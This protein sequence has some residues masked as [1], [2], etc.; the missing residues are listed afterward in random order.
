MAMS[1]F[2]KK[3]PEKGNSSPTSGARRANKDEI[4]TTMDLTNLGD[5]GRALQAA[6]GKIQVSEGSHEE[7]AAVEEAAIL[8]ANASD[9]GACAVLEAAID[10][11]IGKASEELWLMLFDLY[12]LTGQKASFDARS[13]AFTQT[14]EISPPIWDETAPAP[15]VERK[16]SSAP[17]VNLS[18]TLSGNARP[19]FE[20]LARI[21][22]K[23]GKLRIEL[24]R[25]KGI[26]ETGCA[27]LNETL[28]ALKRAKVEVVLF[29]APHALTLIEPKLKVGEKTDQPYWMLA[30]SLIQQTADADRFDQVALDYAIT[31]EESPPSYEPPPVVAPEELAEVAAAEPE[32]EADVDRF[33]MTGVVSG[34][35]PEALRQLAVYASQRTRVEVDCTQ[36]KRLEFVSAGALFNQIAQL[37]GQGKQTLLFRPNAMVAALL[38]VMGI[39]QVAEIERRKAETGK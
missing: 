10:G 9:D 19:Q 16:Q 28:A 5:M 34:N 33:A 7:H 3:P 36:L 6:A 29:G 18:G 22:Q 11:A 24:T 39:D 4:T 21:G 15:A 17:A 23:M 25:L 26:D 31:F 1:L 13:E 8:Y 35:Q 37:Q 30:L 38:R 12:R 14:F 20:Q 32:P 2:G 27:L